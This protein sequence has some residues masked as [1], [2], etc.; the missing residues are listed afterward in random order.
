M[1]VRPAQLVQAP[2][3]LVQALGQWHVHSQRVARRNAL[4]ASTALADRRRELDDVEQF[5][6]TR[7]AARAAGSHLPPPVGASRALDRHA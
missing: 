6:A 4:A 7:A 1:F 5:L 3:H 2:A